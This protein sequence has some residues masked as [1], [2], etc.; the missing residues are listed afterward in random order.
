MLTRRPSTCTSA[1]RGGV[2]RLRAGAAGAASRNPTASIRARHRR[3]SAGAA[4]RRI[5]EEAIRVAQEELDADV[6]TIEPQVQARGFYESSASCRPPDEF[7]DGGVM[8]I[9]MRLCVS[10]KAARGLSRAHRHCRPRR[11][12]RAP[13]S[14]PHRMG[15]EPFFSFGRGA[16]R[17]RQVDLRGGGAP[18]RVSDI[19]LRALARR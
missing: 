13:A 6:I 17:I 9:E 11:R 4:R 8:H 10:G 15:A 19:S 2:C 3:W 1:T 14:R 16:A 5:I 7:D 18:P 12:A